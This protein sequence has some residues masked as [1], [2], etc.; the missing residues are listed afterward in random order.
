MRFFVPL[1]AL[2]MV[3]PSTQGTAAPIAPTG[4]WVVEFADAQCVASRA[5]GPDRLFLKASPLGD[6]VQFGLSRSGQRGPRPIQMGAS[7]QPATGETYRGSAMSW[8]AAGKT[9]SQLW[10]INMPA[11]E[12]ER[13]STSPTLVLRFGDLKR[14]LVSSALPE[15]AKVMKTCV[16]D[17]QK[18]W[19]SEGG[20]AAKARAQLAEYF[21]D[22]DYPADAI[23]GQQTGSTGFA[24]LIDETGKVADCMVVETSGHAVLDMQSCAI[25]KHRARYD[26]ARDSAGKPIK[27]RVTA[28]VTWRIP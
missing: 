10:M 15:M 20:V 4:K 18:V 1:I 11:G 2:A 7:V 5:Y 13:L 23:R 12:F 21:S 8:G 3:L 28:M 9:P 25:L 19:T 22:D 26:P 27:D 6:I 24:M 14:E 17:L 16:D